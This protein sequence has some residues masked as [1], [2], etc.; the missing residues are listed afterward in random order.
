MARNTLDV[1]N[2]TGVSSIRDICDCLIE[3]ELNNEEHFSGVAETLT[4]LGVQSKTEKNTLFQTCH[5]LSFMGSYYLVHFKHFY[6]L[7]G[8][9]NGMYKE[10]VMRLNRIAK[11]LDEW[12]LVKI[13]N[14]EQ[15]T[16]LAD[17][18]R[19]RV[20]KHNDVQNWNLV[21]KYK[22]ESFKERFALYNQ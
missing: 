7:E 10:D 21:T 16:E 19:V 13:K 14:P 2:L 3:I 20:V 15:I 4:R 1:L 9:W 18:S 5:I 12:N 11:L 17:M 8:K 6:L 22:V